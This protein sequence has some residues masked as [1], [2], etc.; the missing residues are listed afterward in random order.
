MPSLNDLNECHKKGAT[1]CHSANHTITSGVTKGI[2]EITDTICGTDK[3][4]IV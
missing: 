3:T 1:V 2:I 4:F